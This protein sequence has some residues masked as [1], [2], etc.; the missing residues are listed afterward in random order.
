[1]K[2]YCAYIDYATDRLMVN[3]QDYCGFKLTYHR[4]KRPIIDPAIYRNRQY[5]RNMMPV[6]ASLATV[7]TAYNPTITWLPHTAAA[8]Q[9]YQVATLTTTRVPEPMPLVGVLRLTDPKMS[10]RFTPAI[11]N[12]VTRS[13]QMVT[14]PEHSTFRQQLSKA[15][16]SG[17]ASAVTFI[18]DGSRSTV[19]GISTAPGPLIV[20]DTTTPG[21]SAESYQS[22]GTEDLFA[23]TSNEE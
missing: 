15:S 5:F 7:M 10:G 18:I 13:A 6:M 3:F 16:A 22:G 8:I 4:P 1:M 11:S 14:S 2:K 17:S 21:S 12:S 20:Y 9:H 23:D 19:G